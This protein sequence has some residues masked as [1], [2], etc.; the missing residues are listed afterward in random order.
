MYV[1]NLLLKNQILLVGWSP[2]GT[3]SV[4]CDVIPETSSFLRVIETDEVASLLRHQT[5]TTRRE[6]IASIYCYVLLLLP[7]CVI[8]NCS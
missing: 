7:L 8:G 3:G 5:T 2:S 1:Q 6:S 4:L